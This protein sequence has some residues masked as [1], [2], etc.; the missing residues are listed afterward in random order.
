MVD[1]LTIALI[2][3][4]GAQTA[5]SLFGGGQGTQQLS[6]PPAGAGLG[7]LGLNPSFQLPIPNTDPSRAASAPPIALDPSSDAVAKAAQ[8]LARQGEP[9]TVPL[10][11][12]GQVGPPTLQQ[13]QAAGVVPTNP[14]SSPGISEVL[15]G[16]P[17]GINASANLLGLGPRER[18]Q[19]RFAPI[20]P[21]GGGRLNPSFQL[22]DT[23]SIGAILSQLPRF[24]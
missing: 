24:R 2:A 10:P 7:N 12:P 16:L 22:P 11:G 1:P 14:R 18:R 23:G 9:G 8:A 21:G 4:A 20:P 17:E 19:T 5:N 3:S 13:D 6:A 15:A